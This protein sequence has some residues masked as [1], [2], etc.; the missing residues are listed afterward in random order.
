M[1]GDPVLFQHFFWFY[2]HP[3]VYIMI[4]PGMAIISEIDRALLAPEDFRLQGDRV[5][6]ARHRVCQFPRL[7]TSYVHQR[8]VGTG[9]DDVFVPDLPGGDTIGG[10]GLQLAGDIVQGLDQ[11]GARRCST[12]S[13]FL[14]LFTIGGLTGIFLGALSVDV[15]LHD[16][17]FVVAHFHYVMM[18]GT[19]MALLG[20]IHY[21]WPK[22]FGKMYS[23]FW[24][25]IGL[26]DHFHRLQYDLFHAVHSGLA[27]DAAPLSSPIWISIS[28][29]MRFRPYG[30]WVLGLG[31]LI[32]V[33]YLIHSLFKGKPAGNNPWGAL[34]FE[35]E[36][37][38]AA[39]DRRTSSCEPVVTHGP[40]DYDTVLIQREPI[41]PEAARGKAEHVR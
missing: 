13:S 3:A 14:I 38:S 30:A 19:V 20:G 39:A 28:R 37:T 1:G 27:G 25:R 9:G 35:W 32:M 34:G 18:G 36:T 21:W 40:Y 5:F 2:S 29:C 11:S 16:T 23:E 15:H 8:A 10:Q 24:A 4:L 33:I 22:M 31:F 12:H 17:Y 41:D 26:R 7:G 6:L